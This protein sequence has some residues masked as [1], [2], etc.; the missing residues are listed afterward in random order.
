MREALIRLAAVLALAAGLSYFLRALPFLL[1]GSGREPPAVIR[2]LGR[3][4]APAVI[5]MLVVYCFVGAIRD[6]C[7]ATSWHGAAELLAAV[8]TVGL[9]LR[10][11]NPLLSITAGTVFYMLLLRL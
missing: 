4:L 8:L 2:Y 1:F 5:A 9:H 10:W 6:G 11:R 3:V 7:L